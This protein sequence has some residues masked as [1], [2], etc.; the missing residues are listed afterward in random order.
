M[1]EAASSIPPSKRR[2]PR[3][4][5][6]RTVHW[7]HRS[8]E[9]HAGA[10]CDVSPDGTFLAPY[11]RAGDS[12]HIGDIVWIVLQVEDQVHTLGATVRWHGWSERHACRGFG[13]EFDTGTKGQAETLLL[14]M[15]P[16]GVFFIPG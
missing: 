16:N 5:V 2:R 7:N 8:G 4:Q 15:D 9:N 12:I 3:H 10:L 6:Y 13:V 14:E 11:G 1:A